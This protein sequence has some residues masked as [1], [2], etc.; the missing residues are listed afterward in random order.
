MHQRLI[1]LAMAYAF[2]Q[3]SGLDK[4]MGPGR[5]KPGPI[6]HKRRSKIAD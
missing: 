1:S 2:A 5:S 3:Q 4:L 6:A